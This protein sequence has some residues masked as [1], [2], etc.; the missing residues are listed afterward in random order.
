MVPCGWTRPGSTHRVEATRQRLVGDSQDRCG[1]AARNDNSASFFLMIF[2]AQAR[3]GATSVL[4]LAAAAMLP[5][6][7]QGEVATAQIVPAIVPALEQTVE[8]EPEMAKP[9][10]SLSRTRT[11]PTS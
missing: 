6:P 4:A 7:V 8:A 3:K 11:M 2:T 10:K 1:Y 5:A 9:V